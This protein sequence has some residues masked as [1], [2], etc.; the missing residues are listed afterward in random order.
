MEKKEKESVL[1]FHG[2]ELLGDMTYMD[3]ERICGRD[4]LQYRT[5]YAF[6]ELNEG[7]AKIDTAARIAL[8]MGTSLNALYSPKGSSW[9]TAGTSLAATEEKKIDSDLQIIFSH[10]TKETLS[11]L[12][13]NLMRN[14]HDTLGELCNQ[15]TLGINADSMAESEDVRDE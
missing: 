3:I 7:K 15:Y 8:A 13:I 6:F 10:L 14:G 4:V 12:S 1:T 5:I 2:K 11:K 9:A